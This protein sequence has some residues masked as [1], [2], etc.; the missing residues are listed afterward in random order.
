MTISV[1]H[2]LYIAWDGANYTEETNY[3]ISAQGDVRYVT[4]YSSLVSGAG[5]TDQMV[6]TLDNSTGRFS[7]LNTSGALYANIGSGGMYMRPVRLDI[8][9]N[10]GTNY[11]RVFTGV[12][13]LPGAQSPTWQETSIVT[14]DARSRDELLLNRRQSTPQS[15]FAA[16]VDALRTED[17][18]IESYIT[19]TGNG[20]TSGD[21][22]LDTGMIQIPYPWMDDESILEEMWLI[23]AACGGRFFAAYDGTFRYESMAAWQIESASTTSQQTYGATG[24]SSFQRVEFRYDDTD[25]YNEIT[26][27][28]SPRII[29]GIDVIWESKSLTT[30]KPGQ[31]QT[32]T[33][34]F[35]APAY[36]IT[37]LEI[38][39]R[40]AAGNNVTSSVTVTPTYYAQRATLSIANAGAQAAY[41]TKLRIL[42]RPIVGAPDQEATK[43]SAT[44]GANSAY[45]SGRI[46]RNR[47]VSGN[48][49]VQ[50][51]QQ[52]EMLAQRILDLSEYPRLQFTL[53]GCVGNPQ[54]RL[55]DR[56]TIDHT[57]IAGFITSTLEAY[58]VGI[59]WNL[60][61][62]GFTQD[63]E[64]VQAS[65]I[66]KHDNDYFI[67]NSHAANGTRKLFY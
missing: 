55:G 45:F 54:R 60:D 22:D 7:P 48:P 40:D 52:A 14:L 25:L 34:K 20:F 44:H 18:I 56:I 43:T 37:G 59:R 13:K 16:D 61:N 33:A 11:Y 6:L 58:I 12:L 21:L 9:I 31:T 27:E 30:V 26:I 3:L 19:Q 57:A 23:A 67:V 10:G 28:A 24:E 63:I 17:D 4:P 47:R 46:N 66:F 1:R 41:L 8:S 42:G 15:T 51:I 29:G 49:Y 36:S 35:D 64:S 62:Q 39:A 65:S 53:M 32:V 50:T 5:I 2:R 38:A